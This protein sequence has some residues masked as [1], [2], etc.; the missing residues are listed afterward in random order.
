MQEDKICNFWIIGD[1]FENV[2]FY[3]KL[4]V[5]N[6]FTLWKG[7]CLISVNSNRSSRNPF[8][9]KLMGVGLD[10]EGE[11]LRECKVVGKGRFKYNNV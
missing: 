3:F 7:F 1:L 5:E 8:E 11:W 10:D 6:I 9:C 2:H 4:I